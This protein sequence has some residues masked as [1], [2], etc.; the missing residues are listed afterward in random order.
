MKQR[1]LPA[2]HRATPASCGNLPQ[3]AR[4][5]GLCLRIGSETSGRAATCSYGFLVASCHSKRSASKETDQ[6]Q[7]SRCCL[8]RPITSATRLACVATIKNILMQGR[9]M[10]KSPSV[11]A[12]G[13]A[14]V[15]TVI[16]VA[17]RAGALAR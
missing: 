5:R 13:R 8:S 12:D 10:A 11:E 1:S 15:V 16:K 9:L 7:P 4:K 2:C 3:T 6:S 14:V 17:Y